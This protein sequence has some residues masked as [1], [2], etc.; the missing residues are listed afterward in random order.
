MNF[1]VAVTEKIQAPGPVIVSV[2]GLG[3]IEFDERLESD[4]P[5]FSHHVAIRPEKLTVTNERTDAE[6]CVRGTVENSS[7]WGDQSQFQVSIDGCKTPL[8]VAAHNLDPL[9][10]YYPVRG[11]QVWLSARSS[12]L[13]RFDDRGN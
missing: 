3:E 5:G 1:L 11:S 2:E 6:I 12:A 4:K 13:L 9:T 10:P 7:Y 8:M